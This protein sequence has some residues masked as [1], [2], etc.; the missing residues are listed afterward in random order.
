M[1]IFTGIEK[2]TNLDYSRVEVAVDARHKGC[3]CSYLPQILCNE[4]Y[5]VRSA[6]RLGRRL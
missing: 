6:G 5:T 2:Y 1:K 3:S 4:T